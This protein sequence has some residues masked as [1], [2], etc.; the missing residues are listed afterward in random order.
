MID[1]ARIIDV[2]QRTAA[3]VRIKCPRER[4]QEVVGPAIQEILAALASQGQQPKGPLFMHHL[5]MSSTDFDVEVGFPLD[6][7]ITADG[8]V[9]PGMLPAA[10]VAQCVYRGPY[11]GLRAAWEAFG[12]RLEGDG[13]VRGELGPIETLWESYL[14]GPET[15]SDSTQWRTELNLPLAP[16]RT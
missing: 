13:H 15:T 11:E 1:A 6:A 12:K 9:V 5:T 14:V 8:H 7:L 10:R 4:I 16:A 2:P 3:V